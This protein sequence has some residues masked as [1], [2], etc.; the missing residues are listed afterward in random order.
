MDK[1]Q[2][3]NWY[4]RNADYVLDCILSRSLFANGRIGSLYNSD[5]VSIVFRRVSG[6][7]TT[8]GFSV[9][10]VAARLAY[11]FANNDIKEWK[12]IASNVTRVDV[13]ESAMEDLMKAIA[14]EVKQVYTSNPGVKFYALHL[15]DEW[16]VSHDGVAAKMRTM[17]TGN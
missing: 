16:P 4:G 7:K 1:K 9:R 2:I 12:K 10:P 5:I 3:R 11:A 15:G 8:K 14:E 6:K 17:H 13:K